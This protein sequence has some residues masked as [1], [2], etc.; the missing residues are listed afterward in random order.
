[1]PTVRI[2]IML[3]PGVLDAPGQAVLQGLRALGYE[4][5]G[6]RM[7]KVVELAVPEPMRGRL[8]EMCRRFLANPLIE[9]WRI[10]DLEAVR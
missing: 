1:M 7:G 9:T 8:D 5:E 3:K 2:T 10:E 4:V 6:V